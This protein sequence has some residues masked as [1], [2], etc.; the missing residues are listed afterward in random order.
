MSKE[1]CIESWG[2]PKSINRT[3]TMYGTHEQW[4]YGNG[5]Y[6]Y[7]ENDKLVTIQN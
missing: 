5:N 7:F 2:K 1:A 3:I 4:I 6:L